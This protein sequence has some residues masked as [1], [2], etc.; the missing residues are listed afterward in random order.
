MNMNN[1]GLQASNSN[2][3]DVG[4]QIMALAKEMF[5][6]TSGEV[7]PKKGRFFRMKWGNFEIDSASID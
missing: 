4:C 3:K 7:P 5:K 1:K 6:D 2:F